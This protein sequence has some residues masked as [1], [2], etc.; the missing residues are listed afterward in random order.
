MCDVN[1]LNKLQLNQVLLEPVFALSRT[2]DT[3][4][5]SIFFNRVETQHGDSLTGFTRHHLQFSILKDL[6]VPQL[7]VDRLLFL[8]QHEQAWPDTFCNI[9]YTLETRVK[10]QKLQ[11]AQHWSLF[12]T[13]RLRHTIASQL[14]QPAMF[15]L[16]NMGNSFGDKSLC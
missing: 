7:H 13:S 8:R 5:S 3:H 10:N 16:M 14:L 11:Q 15:L 6:H 4:H 9:A 2:Q 1:R 12:T